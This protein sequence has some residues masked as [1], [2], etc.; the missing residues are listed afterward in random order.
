[1]AV[2]WC[3]GA[4]NLAVVEASLKHEDSILTSRYLGT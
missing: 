3:C 4:K 2:G 1:M